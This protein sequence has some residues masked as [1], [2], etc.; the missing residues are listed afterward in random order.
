MKRPRLVLAALAVLALAS[1][2][3]S[4]W[5]AD[6][7]G[8]DMGDQAPAPGGGNRPVE[9]GARS[10]AAAHGRSG[11]MVPPRLD[12]AVTISGTVIDAATHEGVGGVEVVFRSDAGEETTTAGPD[13]RYRIDVPPGAYRAF[14]RDDTVLSVGYADHVRLPGLP[15]ADAAGAPDEALMP[16]VAASADADGVDLT[17]TRGGVVR[18]KVVDR[19]GRPIAGAV[20][21]AHSSHLRPTLG[22]DV[23]ETGADGAFELRLPAGSYELD[24]SHARF[25]GIAGSDEERELSIDPGE[26]RTVTY[27]L[28]AG[29]V[30]AGRVVG[31]GGGPA[32]DGAIERQ[33]GPGDSDFMPAGRIAADGTF[34]WTTTA[35]AD[36]V[37]RA[38]PWKSPPSP[39]R[40]FSCRDGARHDGV[41]FTLTDR[42]PDL[43]GVL[44]DRS[45]APVPHA[46]IDL[47]SLD[48]STGQ[49][50]RTD[51]NGRWSVFALAAGRYQVTAYA[52]GRG[53]LAT[54]ISAPQAQVR[55]ALGGT[56]RIEGRTPRLA[57]GSFE[58]SLQR[59]HDGEVPV[60]LPAE[61]RLV[62]VIDHAFV[63]EDVP[64]CDLQLM[65]TWRGRTA[66]ASAEV[67]AGGAARVELA[68]GPPREKVVRGTVTDEVGRPAAGVSVQGS[69]EDDPPTSTTTDAAGR[70]TLH[71]YGGAVVIATK[72]A[73]DRQYAAGG[74][75]SSEDGD[76][77]IDLELSVVDTPPAGADEESE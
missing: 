29:C 22:T 39:P 45:G 7:P 19:S 60:R 3:A 16:T 33:F 34:R 56:G 40:A 65:T 12:G 76:E 55:L 23:A 17:V 72:E 68:V 46:F 64:A 21:R 53:V 49:Q 28:V 11:A 63:V 36:V 44:V 57:R 31:V 73:G 6:E 71:T 14:V 10:P 18:G 74:E 24:V 43:D 8:E 9:R 59:C 13:G 54:A 42:G 15:T 26:V 38:W 58:L 69:F 5:L 4:T 51:E 27:T 62:T 35:E 25:A 67:P 52:P 61:H 32:G 1:W 47:V 66:Y 75:V 20:L 70:Y 41:V 30:I 77:T 2:R 37:L 48:G 50:E